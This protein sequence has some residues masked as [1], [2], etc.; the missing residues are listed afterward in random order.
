MKL[1]EE[2]KRKIEE[3]NQKIERYERD[4]TERDQIIEKLVSFTLRRFTHIKF[5][6]FFSIENI[7]IY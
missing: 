3:L 2:A 1:Y 4:I 5:H 6:F 7:S